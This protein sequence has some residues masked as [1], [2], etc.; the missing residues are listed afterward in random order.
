MTT[1]DQERPWLTTWAQVLDS[2]DELSRDD[3]VCF[4]PRPSSPDEPCLVADSMELD[5]DDDLPT[6]AVE[7]GWQVALLKEQ[8]ED[9]VL[10]LRAQVPDPGID[11]VL[12]AIAYYLDND[13]FLSVS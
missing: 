1:T 2:L 7:R 9:V 10:N 12:R 8:I 11:L 6:E 13:A 5:D 3:M 4:G